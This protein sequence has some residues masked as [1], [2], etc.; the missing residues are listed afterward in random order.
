M[1]ILI[2]EEKFLPHCRVQVSLTLSK[3]TLNMIKGVN[4]IGKSTFAAV[5]KER[6]P[7]ETTLIEQQPLVH[8]YSR[9]LLELKKIFIK[10]RPR[11]LDLILFERIW[12]ALNLHEIE[13]HSLHQL[14]GG[15]NQSLKLAL[16][17]SIKNKLI[18]IDEPSQYLDMN[19]KRNLTAILK[20]LMNDSFILLI[21]HESSWLS[22]LPQK[23]SEFFIE[24]GTLK[25]RYV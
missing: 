1:N 19:R 23:T 16:G 7:M 25:A 10:A 6:Y 20:E 3:G 2:E 11:H 14:S 21:E 17:L 22:E 12:R 8:F 9:T 13:N 24:E 4:G 5:V 18:I 15:E